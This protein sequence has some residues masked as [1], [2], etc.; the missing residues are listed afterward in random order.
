MN[1][2]SWLRDPAAPTLSL[3]QEQRRAFSRPPIA[4]HEHPAWTIFAHRHP[5]FA[6]VSPPRPITPRR[7]VRAMR[8]RL[9]FASIAEPKD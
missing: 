3:T 7:I 8:S 6:R 4:W 5:E 9:V 1:L 2:P